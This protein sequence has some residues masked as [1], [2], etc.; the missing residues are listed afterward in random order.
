MN[1]AIYAEAQGIGF[2]IPI[3]RAKRIVSDLINYGSV[4]QAWIGL[5]VQ[6][7]DATLAAYLNLSNSAGVIITP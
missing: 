5:A 1:T 2:A 6:P 7:I 3:N 4:V